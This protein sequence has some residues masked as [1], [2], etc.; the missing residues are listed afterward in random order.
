MLFRSPD[1]RYYWDEEN[2]AL[3]KAQNG[4]IGVDHIKLLRIMERMPVEVA[5][6][7]QNVDELIDEVLYVARCVERSTAIV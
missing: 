3:A 2:A 4:R 6:R 7:V 5:L 1:L